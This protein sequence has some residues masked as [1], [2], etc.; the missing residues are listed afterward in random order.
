KGPFYAVKIWPLDVGTSG[1]L[2]TDEHA[3]VLKE[4]GSI[5]PGLYASGNITAPVVGPTYP[6]AGA[7]IG[8]GIAFGYVAA[9][10]ALGANEAAAAA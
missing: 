5:I 8:G 7:S 1:G 9:R 10:H 4:D 6:G 2:V 3:R